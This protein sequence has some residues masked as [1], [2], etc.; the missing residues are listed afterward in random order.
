MY[1]GKGPCTSAYLAS[2]AARIKLDDTQPWDVVTLLPVYGF[3]PQVALVHYARDLHLR[4]W[5]E[6]IFAVDHVACDNCQ[7][8]AKQLVLLSFINLQHASAACTYAGLRY[9]AKWAEDRVAELL[10]LYHK[11]RLL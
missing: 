10:T 11:D 1:Y 6:R 8:P 3:A 5:H 9:V 4:I 7:S 2:Q